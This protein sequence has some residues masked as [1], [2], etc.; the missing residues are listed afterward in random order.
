MKKAAVKYGLSILLGMGMVWVVQNNYGYNSG[1]EPVQRYLVLCNAFTIPGTILLM[2]GILVFISGTGALDGITYA[3][4]W[5]RLTLLPF[6]KQPRYD[7]Y[8]KA[9][10]ERK[11]V[12]GGFLM[13]SGAL[14][15]AVAIV[16][17]VLFYSVY[18][19]AR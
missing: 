17:L 19:P 5:L 11:K 12:S 2:V 1:M 16:F 13:I 14:F 18:T 7:E 4:R 6:G 3:L 10:R 8:V 9:R 15:L